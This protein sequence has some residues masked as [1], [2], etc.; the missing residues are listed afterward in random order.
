MRCHVPLR[1]LAQPKK[2]RTRKRQDLILSREMMLRQTMSLRNP[3]LTR[4]ACKK[5]IKGIVGMIE[6]ST[7]ADE[8]SKSSSAEDASDV[9]FYERCYQQ[10]VAW[11]L[12]PIFFGIAWVSDS[13]HKDV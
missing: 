13:Y 6:E 8:A 12:R 9:A 1:L 7:D 10:A 5:A 11:I 4:S 2:G 3:L